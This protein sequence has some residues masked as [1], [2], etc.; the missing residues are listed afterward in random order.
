MERE[1]EL[2]ECSQGGR[3][4]RKMSSCV[5]E[6]ELSGGEGGMALKVTESG[7]WFSQQ[8]GPGAHVNGFRRFRVEPRSC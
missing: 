1:E 6:G 7:M 2:S 3:L 4:V 8:N 5:I